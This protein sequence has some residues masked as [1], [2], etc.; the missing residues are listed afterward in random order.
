MGN[1]YD[2]DF[3]K[4]DTGNHSSSTKVNEIKIGE[5]LASR[6]IPDNFIGKI[7]EDLDFSKSTLTK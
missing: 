6:S 2:Q 5:N 3:A 7:T 1:T 4:I